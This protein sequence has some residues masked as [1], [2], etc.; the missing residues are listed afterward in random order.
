[1]REIK[2]YQCQSGEGKYGTKDRSVMEDKVEKKIY[3]LADPTRSLSEQFINFNLSA[4]LKAGWLK[5]FILT[6]DQ[7][8]IISDKD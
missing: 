1:M 4:A 8:E 5:E 6:E 7:I 3:I 2:R